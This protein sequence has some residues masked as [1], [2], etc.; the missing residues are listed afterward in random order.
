MRTAAPD[1]SVRRVQNHAIEI[2]IKISGGT[3]VKAGW[4]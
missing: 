1:R 2:A 3:A 4:K